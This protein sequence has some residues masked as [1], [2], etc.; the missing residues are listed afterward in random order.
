MKE[1]S[2]RTSFSLPP[3]LLQD[4]DDVT[5]LLGFEE[6]SKTIQTAIRN[7]VDQSRISNDPDAYATGT[8]LLLY[9]HTIRRIDEMIT[10]AGHHFGRLIVSTL[11]VHLEDPNCLNVIVVRGK[12]KKILELEQHL[13]KLR[14][15]TQLK[16]S[17]VL[18]KPRGAS[19]LVEG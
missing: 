8:I 12:I 7:L 6:R 10:E 1:R 17:Y 19:Q 2:T 18:T 13:R 11:H 5:S 14:G 15:I 16:F 9:D 4:L 3:K